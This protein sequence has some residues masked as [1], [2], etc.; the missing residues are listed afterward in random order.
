MPCKGRLIRPSV[1]R[2]NKHYAVGDCHGRNCMIVG[3]TTTVQSVPIT[4]NVV[5]SNST[6]AKCTRCIIMQ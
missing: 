2:S 3:S 6:P 5:G 4:T 1:H